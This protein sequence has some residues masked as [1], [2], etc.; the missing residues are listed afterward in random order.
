MVCTLAQAWFALNS[1]GLYPKGSALR[2][3][4][5]LFCYSGRCLRLQPGAEAGTF[6]SPP[7]IPS[8]H[9][10]HHW[11]GL[12]GAGPILHAVV[13]SLHVQRGWPGLDRGQW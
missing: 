1:H 5:N 7:R 8:P 2:L 6:P 11:V 3:A 4:C 12:R 9:C 13:R 10:F